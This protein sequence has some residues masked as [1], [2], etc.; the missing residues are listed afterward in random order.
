MI[1]K[2]QRRLARARATRRSFGH[3][4]NSIPV[5][6]LISLA[7]ACA[8]PVLAA[9]DD[10]WDTQFGAPGA[11]GKVM[12]MVASGSDLYVTG[13]FTDAGESGCVGIAK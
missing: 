9:D 3:I 1:S 8:P 2:T 10:H 4:T 11:D 5:C 12:S 13:G 7:I 6:C